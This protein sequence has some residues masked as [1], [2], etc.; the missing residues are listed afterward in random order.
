MLLISSYCGRVL[1]SCTVRVETFVS[2]NWMSKFSIQPERINITLTTKQR[3]HQTKPASQLD[4]DWRLSSVCSL[5]AQDCQQLLTYPRHIRFFFIYDYIRRGKLHNKCLRFE[6]RPCPSS[7][8]SRCMH[9]RG[10]YNGGG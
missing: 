8:T 3:S 1:G 6:L 2:H 7:L 9:V 5:L 10:R 4:C